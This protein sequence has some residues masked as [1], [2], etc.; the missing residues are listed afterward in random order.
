MT[1]WECEKGSDRFSGL[2]SFCELRGES[3]ALDVDK[4]KWTDGKDTLSPHLPL[5]LL[6]T[7]SA[8]S[9]IFPDIRLDA[10]RLVHLLLAHVPSHVTGSWPHASSSSAGT[11]GGATILEGLRL[12]IG[13]GGD[14]GTNAQI[15]RLSPAAKLVTLKAMLAFIKASLRDGD[16]HEGHL[17]AGLFHGW[18]E[19]DEIERSAKSKGKQRAVEREPASNAIVEEGW[20]FGNV[21][22]EEV[23][24]A[25]W[26]I[27]RLEGDGA[28]SEAETVLETL[29]V[30]FPQFPG[31]ELQADSNS[32]STCNCTLCC[33]L[34]FSSRL[35]PPSRHHKHHSHRQ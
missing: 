21:Y 35:R 16:E 32:N 14:K 34:L 19:H 31:C 20:L 24:G 22:R 13:L 17:P 1:G 7:S 5:L 28:V 8:L 11:A 4:R 15:G 2:V 25:S 3:S 30:S 29:A 12:A 18:L 27:G 33:C 26:E 23:D 10:C 9:H 6:Q